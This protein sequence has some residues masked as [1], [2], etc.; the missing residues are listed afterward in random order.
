MK[1]LPLIYIPYLTAM[2]RSELDGLTA[3]LPYTHPQQVNDAPFQ[4]FH[5]HPSLRRRNEDLWQ[6]LQEQRFPFDRAS[7]PAISDADMRRLKPVFFCMCT[8][9]RAAHRR[10]GV[11]TP[12]YPGLAS[13]FDALPEDAAPGTAEDLALDYAVRIERSPEALA[14]VAGHFVSELLRRVP[15]A[16]PALSDLLNP[17]TARDHHLVEEM[18]AVAHTSVWEMLNDP[19]SGRQWNAQDACRKRPAGSDGKRY[20]NWLLAK[21]LGLDAR[22]KIQAHAFFESPCGRALRDAGL[23]SMAQRPRPLFFGNQ[24]LTLDRIDAVFGPDGQRD[25]RVTTTAPGSWR[26][27]ADGHPAAGHVFEPFD[28]VYPAHKNRRPVFATGLIPAHAGKKDNATLLLFDNDPD[29]AG[30]VHQL[31]HF[32]CSTRVTRVFVDAAEPWNTHRAGGE[33][34]PHQA[35]D[36]LD[37]VISLQPRCDRENAV[38]VGFA[39]RFHRLAAVPGQSVASAFRDA[40]RATDTQVAAPLGLAGRTQALVRQHS[41]PLDLAFAALRCGVRFHFHRV[42]AP[43]GTP[44]HLRSYFRR[45][46][47]L[48]TLG[49]P[50][51]TARASARLRLQPETQRHLQR[52]LHRLRDQWDQT[53]HRT[54][55]PAHRQHSAEKN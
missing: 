13:V 8:F 11:P 18:H 48:R 17:H 23:I 7:L 5:I 24:P 21:W 28:H 46:T 52:R 42:S 30:H 53:P 44:T 4:S 35:P 15:R 1:N 40:V 41:T 31:R 9:C 51:T 39:A 45:I 36:S 34:Q 47:Q 32:R 3:F 2:L 27:P 26:P 54:T 49:E 14:L 29:Q 43:Q 19:A 12:Y 25:P 6:A 55:P 22:G 50:S 10:N 33:P 37:A 20:L 38:L 16:L